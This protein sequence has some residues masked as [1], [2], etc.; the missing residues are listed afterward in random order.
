[1][2]DSEEKPRELEVLPAEA[3]APHE[4]PVTDR[5]VSV[6]AL[7]TPSTLTRPT[8]DWAPSAL[9]L[10]T[11][12]EFEKNLEMAAKARDRLARV[13][14]A[15]MKEGVDYGVVPGTDK[16]TLLKPGAET[17]NKL[18]R[19]YP[20][21]ERERI[22]GDGKNSPPIEYIF[23]CFL[24]AGD[25]HGP[26]M[27]QGEGSCNT[28]EKKYRWRGGTRK[29][30]DCGAEAIIKGKADYGGGW[31]CWKKK[32][33]CG[34]NFDDHDPAI[35]SQSI[36]RVENPDQHDLDNT[37]LN[38]A[39]KRAFV[40]ATLTAH[41]ASG[42]FTQDVGDDDND[43]G[44]GD[45]PGKPTDGRRPSQPPKPQQSAARPEAPITDDQ[46]K[47]A[48]AIAKRVGTEDIKPPVAAFEVICETLA[49]AQIDLPP[50]EERRNYSS[51]RK[52]VKAAITKR[53]YDGFVNTIERY[54][55]PE[56]GFIDP[57]A[58]Q[59]EQAAKEKARQKAAEEHTDPGADRDFED[60]NYQPPG[61]PEQQELAK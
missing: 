6:P 58:Y 23:R 13:Q 15:V 40:D 53:R 45:D 3:A 52:H 38:I 25:A 43:G 32:D 41:A 7:P 26:V 46:F 27:Y 56:V 9:A 21:F 36:D 18:A 22:L 59:L 51:L 33:G 8:D 31:V 55:G 19:L 2:A 47:R 11:D 39:K 1:M 61:E 35:L 34:A 20:T 37:V 16:R 60:E 10:M 30:P 14:K 24:H 50:E 49:V 5:A 54:R 48:Y 42:L 57:Q 28:W 4:A 17:L 44:P 12:D 29:C